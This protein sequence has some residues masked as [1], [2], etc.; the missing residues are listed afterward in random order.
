MLFKKFGAELIDYK[1]KKII[2]V[3]NDAGC[4]Q[5]ISSWVKINNIQFS[6]IVTGPAENIFKEKK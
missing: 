5:L 4:S 6:G 3:C 2:I 1:D